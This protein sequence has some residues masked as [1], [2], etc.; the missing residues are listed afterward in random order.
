V[1]GRVVR[2]IASSTAAGPALPGVE[3]VVLDTAWTP[4]AADRS[5]LR[6][7]RPLIAAAL[8]LHQ[9]LAEAMALI[10]GWAA[11]AGIVERLEVA[12]VSHW[13]RRRIAYWRWLHD[14]L[15]WQW[16]LAELAAEGRIERLELGADEVELGQVARLVGAAQG[17]AVE[18][19]PSAQPPAAL[20][21]VGRPA[22][23]ERFRNRL[24]AP[25][26]RTALADRTS[27]LAVRIDR[28]GGAGG[29]ILVLTDPAVHQTVTTA[30]RTARVDPFLGPVVEALRSTSLN[31]VVFEIGARAADDST[32]AGLQVTG[33]E[34][35]LPGSIL[36]EVF[37]DP[38]DDGPAAAA[39]G[40][41]AERLAGPLPALG[42][43]GLDLAPTIVAELRAFAATGLASELRQEA[44]IGRFLGRLRPAA[45]L[46][47]N[48]YSR[49]EWIVAAR[50]QAIPIAAVQH[51]IIHPLHAGYIL[52]GRPASLKL[53]DRTYVFGPYEARLLTGSSVYRPAEVR[54]SGAPRL[55][56]GAGRA[57]DA[58]ERAAIRASLGVAQGARLV[59]FSS[60]SSAAV[61]RTVVAAAFDSVMDR[62]WPA[63]HLV[64]KLHPAEDDGAFYPNLIE[65]L[66]RARGFAPPPTTIVKEI[67]LLRLLAAADAHLG[68][69][70]TVLTDA[71]TVGTP[72]LIV[73]SLSGSDLLGYVRAGVAQPVRSGADL[74]AALEAPRNPTADASARTAFLADHFAGGPAV[75]RIV[76]DLLAGFTSTIRLRAAVEA[77]AELLLAW[78]NDPVTRSAS[79]HAA[80][81]SPAE[82]RRWLAERLASTSTTLWIGELD[83]LPV[84]QVRIE[85]DPAGVGEVGISVA[86]S[87]R[88]AGVGRRLLNSALREASRS[89]P[90]TAFVARVRPD[91]ER[92]LGLFHAAGF[93]DE[94]PGTSAG[95]PSLILRAPATR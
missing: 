65:G 24:R 53:V 95:E 80:A 36:S 37:A 56:L 19:A 8:G 22:A 52:P 12:G 84:G 70:S 68:V 15:I 54:V 14:R 20:S 51:G 40:V 41:V 38:A 34:G 67:D 72:N 42:V 16:V 82:H 25:A 61:R 5:D 17:W 43:D 32:W 21:Q 26:R 49:P 91:N 92:S 71:V 18:I 88:G 86:P 74:L 79:F 7:A 59:V 62:S 6:S 33:R 29:T 46:L 35:V 81:I 47:I 78:A 39:A 69:Y 87:A 85:L 89:L 1:T 2:F 45:V 4:E 64:V 3:Q 60:T 73:T 48:E 94:G 23:L 63:V 83:G 57:L 76:A 90:V 77:D 27:A 13:Y 44:R 10:D 31:P 55:D 93:V 9:P 30:G 58:D 11:R 75:A 28:L 66:A 50:R